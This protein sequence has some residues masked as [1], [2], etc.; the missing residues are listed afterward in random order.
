[1]RETKAS[2]RLLV[3]RPVSSLPRPPTLVSPSWRAMERFLLILALLIP[4]SHGQHDKGSL[5]S[6]SNIVE[7]KNLLPN[8]LPDLPNAIHYPIYVP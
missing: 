7:N 6:S 3:P 4:G 8:G 5:G 1:M 2:L